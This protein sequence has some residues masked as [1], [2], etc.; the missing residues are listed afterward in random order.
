M[1][2]IR[3]RNGVWLVRQHYTESFSQ[4]HWF[5]CEDDS[6]VRKTIL[7]CAINL[8]RYVRM[9]LKVIEGTSDIYQLQDG[10]LITKQKYSGYFCATPSLQR[11]ENVETILKHMDSGVWVVKKWVTTLSYNKQV[12]ANLDIKPLRK[13]YL[14]LITSDDRFVPY[15]QISE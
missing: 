5:V 6:D 14:I 4:K 13:E 15:E 12:N 3:K 1:I 7:D 11:R 8:D 9:V 2:R 10:D